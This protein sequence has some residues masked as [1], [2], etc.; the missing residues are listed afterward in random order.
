MLRFRQGLA[1]EIVIDQES[2]LSGRL[3][4]FDQLTFASATT[5]NK[6]LPEPLALPVENGVVVVS[7]FRRT[8]CSMQAAWK[9]GL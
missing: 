2:H 8:A 9:K 5:P 7:H 3:V 1:L 6:A 4:N